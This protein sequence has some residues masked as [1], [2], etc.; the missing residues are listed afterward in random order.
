MLDYCSFLFGSFTGSP[1]FQ[2]DSV[3]KNL[4]LL[5]WDVRFKI[6]LGT[7]EGLTYLHEES[8][9]RIIHRDIKLSNIM[10]DE[11]LEPKI[12]DFGLARLF[13]KDKTHVSTAIAG[14][15]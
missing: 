11:D 4:Q 8:K 7:A 13:P 1:L 12:A 9:L 2:F 5:R 3:K 10:L 14:T 15:L 6:I